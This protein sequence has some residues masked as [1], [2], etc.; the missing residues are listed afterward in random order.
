MGRLGTVASESRPSPS[1]RDEC[2]EDKQITQGTRPLEHV[3]E[4]T[5]HSLQ[6]PNVKLRPAQPSSS[7]SSKRSNGRSHQSSNGSRNL[8]RHSSPD[9]EPEN[10]FVDMC[11]RPF[12]GVVLCATGIQD[13]VRPL[14]QGGTYITTRLTSPR[15]LYSRLRLSSVPNTAKT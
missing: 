13:K 1:G 15:R 4:V 10:T 8:V 11:P 3:S 9:N 6:V 5:Y 12:K 7:T 14:S 2:K